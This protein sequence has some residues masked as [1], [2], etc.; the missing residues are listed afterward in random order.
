MISQQNGGPKTSLIN[1]N[2][3]IWRI[4]NNAFKF[5]YIVIVRVK[6]FVT[7]LFWLK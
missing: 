5:Y 2:I 4:T 6:N 1:Q 3:F 7:K